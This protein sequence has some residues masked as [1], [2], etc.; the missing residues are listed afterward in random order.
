MI[1]LVVNISI[2]FS[3]HG[4]AQNNNELEKDFKLSEKEAIELN[5]IFV[6]KPSAFDFR[7]KNVA[8]TINNTGTQLEEKV[9]F[10]KKYLTPVIEGQRKNVCTLL[11][12]SPKEKRQSGGFDAVIQAPLKIF[13]TTQREYLI[14]KLKQV[15]LSYEEKDT[16]QLLKDSDL[17]SAFILNSSPTFKGYFFQGSDDEHHYFISKWDHKSDKYFKIYKKDLSVYFPMRFK[18][19]E[20]RISLHSSNTVFG[21]NK[22]VK[23]YLK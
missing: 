5:N 4:I 14:E 9:I 20:I 2:L 12:L 16:Y 7:G 22:W 21:E 3:I 17:Q 19:G 8:Y 23:L 15:A 11:V 18:F 10:H 13:T 1:S 6:E